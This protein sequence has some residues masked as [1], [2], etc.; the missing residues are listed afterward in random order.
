MKDAGLIFLLGLIALLILV[1]F[2]PPAIVM[3]VVF[4]AGGNLWP[5]YFYVQA[6]WSFIVL[7]LV[8]DE[9]YG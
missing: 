7:I 3:L 6:L 8:L 1:L 2:I 5:A 4:L 9:M